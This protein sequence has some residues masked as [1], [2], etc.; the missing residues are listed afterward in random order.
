M[1]RALIGAILL[2]GSTIFA[3]CGFVFVA[4]SQPSAYRS[5]PAYCSDCHYIGAGYTAHRQC[6]HYEIKVAHGG[7]YY[8]PYGHAK[9]NEFRFVKFNGSDHRT[10]N[11]SDRNYEPEKGTRARR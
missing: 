2:A 5:A 7:Y 1:K 10:E 6:G 4:R 11:R 8:R 3:G 9:H